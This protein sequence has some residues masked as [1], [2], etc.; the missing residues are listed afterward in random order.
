MTQVERLQYI[1]SHTKF[2]HCPCGFIFL[3]IDRQED[4]CP[5]CSKKAELEISYFSLI[6]FSQ[7]I[8]L[9]TTILVLLL[10]EAL[11]ILIVK[12]ILSSSI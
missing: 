11:Y 12:V 3:P 5:Q 6:Y 2:S 1:K 10:I 7:L 9:V 8:I 4:D